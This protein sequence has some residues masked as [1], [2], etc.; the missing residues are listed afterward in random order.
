MVRTIP[1]RPGQSG[2]ELDRRIAALALPALGSIAAEPAY[3]LADTA[4]VGHLGRTPLGAVAIASTALTMTAWLAIFLTTATTSAVA[5]LA[6]ARSW[7]R[8]GRSIGA[9]YLV[10]AGGGLAV[11]ALVAVAAPWVTALLGA[12]G[13]VLSGSVG[14]LRASAVG[15]P[16]LYLSY[17]GNGHLVGLANVHTPLRIAVSANVLNVLLEVLLVY[18]AHLGLLGS[19]WGTVIAQAAAAAWHAAASRRAAVRPGPLA[20]RP[21]RPARTPLAGPVHPVRPAVTTT[22]PLPP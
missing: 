12:N 5:G 3:S 17:A 4:I 16:F 19:A 15:I 11:A 10:A 9:A 7:D 22:R 1:I 6:A 2:R 13:A 21:R 8:A 14:Y 18:G 20:R